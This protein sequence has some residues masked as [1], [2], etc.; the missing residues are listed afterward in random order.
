MDISSLGIPN[1]RTTKVGSRREGVEIVEAVVRLEA[2]DGYWVKRWENGRA[3]TG[4]D[5]HFG[6]R[7]HQRFDSG[8]LGDRARVHVESFRHVYAKRTNRNR[9]MG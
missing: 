2:W 6:L 3:I 7:L 9:L 5:D 1:I 8:S 4:G